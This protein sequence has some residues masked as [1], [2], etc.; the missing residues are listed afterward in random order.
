MMES[1][2]MKVRAEYER[3]PVT[4]HHG[5]PLTY[6]VGLFFIHPYI[7]SAL[8]VLVRHVTASI[9]QDPAIPHYIIPLSHSLH[10]ATPY[11]YY[12]TYSV[13]IPHNP[14]ISQ[15]YFSCNNPASIISLA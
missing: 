9:R 3:A 8:T 10:S 2:H 15:I 14:V 13:L 1:I 4:A 6:V 11:N 5:G 12:S 7:R